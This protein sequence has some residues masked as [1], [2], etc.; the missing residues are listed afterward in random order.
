MLALGEILPAKRE[1]RFLF[2]YN[3]PTK[4]EELQ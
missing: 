2:Y 1:K 3:I 4:R